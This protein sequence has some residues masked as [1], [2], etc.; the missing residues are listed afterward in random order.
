MNPLPG[1]LPVAVMPAQ[2]P[3]PVQQQWQTGGQ[4]PAYAATVSPLQGVGQSAGAYGSAPPPGY[5]QPVSP[6]HS[7][8][9]GLAIKAARKQKLLIILI[10]GGAVLFFTIIVVITALL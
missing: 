8:D 3:G 10:T 2:V 7:Q 6:L 5:G 1:G 4:D 9:P